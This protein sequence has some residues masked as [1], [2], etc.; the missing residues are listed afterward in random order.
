MTSVN[1]ADL[2]RVEAAARDLGMGRVAR[3]EA[4]PPGNVNVVVRA[5]L[6]DGTT[7]I[8][9]W[10]NERTASSFA[11]AGYRQEQLF[12][13]HA[14]PVVDGIVPSWCKA[15]FETPG[16]MIAM[17]ELAGS[18]VAAALPR[19]A[20]DV[21]KPLLTQLA[22]CIARIH[23]APL[24]ASVAALPRVGPTTQDEAE[25]SW[26]RLVAY[27]VRAGFASSSAHL[28]AVGRDLVATFGDTFSVQALHG[29]FRAANVLADDS[30]AGLRVTGIIDGE[31]A[32]RGPAESDIA[33]LAFWDLAARRS[34]WEWFLAAYEDVA[35]LPPGHRIRAFYWRL[36][37]A[38]AYRAW[39]TRTTDDFLVGYAEQVLRDGVEELT[40]L[41]PRTLP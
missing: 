25:E 29:D 21:A 2:R 26:S 41:K 28:M 16:P 19:L 15:L 6:T 9:K 17:E 30:R 14:R 22:R 38:T 35:P 20:V 40:A 18:S 27:L 4:L 11:P 31:A 32:C 10:P 36:A 23:Q 24:R 13:E 5:H 34:L 39:G 3:V 1:L 37:H 12:Y 7:A 8:V 33:R